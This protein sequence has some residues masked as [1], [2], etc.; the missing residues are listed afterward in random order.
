MRPASLVLLAFSLYS[1]D[2]CYSW[3][4]LCPHLQAPLLDFPLQRRLLHV[5]LPGGGG[6]VAVR[7]DQ[8]LADLVLQLPVLDDAVEG[9]LAD[10]EHPGR[11]LAVA[12]RQ[13][14]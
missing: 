6:E 13:R 3:L 9:A 11:L 5:Q 4:L 12:L 10:A 14:Q 8:G 1:C 7:F 2:S